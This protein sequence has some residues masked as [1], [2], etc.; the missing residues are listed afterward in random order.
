MVMHDTQVAA[1]FG[2]VSKGL[3]ARVN[4]H[5]ADGRTV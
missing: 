1:C 4:L 2:K 3:N 5:T